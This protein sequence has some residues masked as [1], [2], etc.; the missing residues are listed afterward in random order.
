MNS[1]INIEATHTIVNANPERLDS[2]PSPYWLG[3]LDHLIHPS[4]PINVVWIY[5]A[6]TQFSSELVPFSRLRHALSLLLDYYPT[7]TGRLSTEPGSGRRYLDRFGSGI[8]LFE[9][10]C[11]DAL[12]TFSGSAG[13]NFD[14]FDFPSAGDSLLAPWEDSI[15]S[16]QRDV[17]LTVQHTR[18]ACGSVAVGLRIA[19]IVCGVGGFLQLY[20]DLAHLYRGLKFDMKTTPQLDEVPAIEP[21]IAGKIG[22]MPE[23][24]REAALEQC[25]QGFSLASVAQPDDV[26]SSEE[27]KSDDR[28]EAPT[29]PPIIGRSMRFSA[30]ELSAIKKLATPPSG[31]PWVSTFSA[32]SAHIFQRIH[33]ARLAHLASQQLPASSLATPSLTTRAWHKYPLYSGAEL[34]VAPIF[35]G[36]TFA[37]AAMVDRVAYFLQPKDSNGGIDVVISLSEPVWEHLDRDVEFRQP[38]YS[39][40]VL[41]AIESFGIV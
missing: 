30:A 7:L 27:D 19:H 10:T 14:I 28:N 15:G 4:V 23:K 22:G 6:S 21:F 8:S 24:E 17:L 32:L 35:V 39:T 9:A 20:Q 18:F 40:Q 16:A 26:T 2:L 41:A 25:P 34:D 38:G 36:R 31:S 3:P 11:N 12:T 1:S 33:K 5:Q 13:V 37:P 29:A